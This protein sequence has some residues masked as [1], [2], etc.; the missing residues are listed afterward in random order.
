VP[1]KLI[2]GNWKMNGLRAD[3]VKLAKTVAAGAKA[4][5]AACDWLVCP[6]F[7]LIAPV[8][9]VLRDSGV[10]LGGQDCHPQ[11]KGAHTGDI[12]APMLADL[13]C[14]YVIVGHSER[15]HDHG[16]NNTLV[17]AKAEAALDA[18]LTPII[19]IGETE[20]ERTAGKTLGVLEDQLAGS[21]PDA[22]SAGDFVVA[23]EPVWAIGTG[24]TATPDDVAAVHD[25]IR[26]LLRHRDPATGEAVRILYGG[27]VKP[28]NAGELL[29]VPHVDGAL[30]GGASLDAEAFLAIGRA[31]RD[32]DRTVG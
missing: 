16:E 19:C 30:V 15:R 10:A 13:G 14:A 1:R 5:S 24:K 12:A 26:G 23:Y 3:G 31:C 20:D 25:H 7:T 22:A 8:A 2:A 21:L 28:A 6:P 32:Q 27:S 29:A 4:E 9:E 11:P 17:R 18:G